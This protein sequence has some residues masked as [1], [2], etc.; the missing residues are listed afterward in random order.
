MKKTVKSLVI[1]ASVAAIAGIGA[2]S[3]AKWDNTAENMTTS[4]TGG[5]TATITTIGFG[6]GVTESVDK[7]LV[8]WDQ[9]EGVNSSTMVN[10]YNITLPV[11]GDAIADYKIFATIKA[12]AA[13]QK[14]WAG[15]YKV[16]IDT[17]PTVTVTSSE[18]T[19]TNW[20]AVN[21][22]AKTNVTAES[23]TLTATTYYAHVVLVSSDGANDMG[24]SLAMTFELAKPV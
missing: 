19:W 9:V 24:A 18:S 4:P 15:T 2:I 17:N 7:A 23:T 11:V 16:L 22:N 1:A 10:V 8:P 21:D 6:E 3:F 5:N 14:V 20:V 12:T 13:S